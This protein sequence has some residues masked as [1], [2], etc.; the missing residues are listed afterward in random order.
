[1]AAHNIA[2][3]QLSELKKAHKEIEGSIQQWLQS[4]HPQKERLENG[5]ATI[6][7]MVIGDNP[8]HLHEK[9]LQTYISG[10]YPGEEYLPFFDNCCI[11]HE[12]DGHHI[13]LDLWSIEGKG[14]GDRYR[15]LVYSQTNVFILLYRDSEAD[16][17]ENIR[18]CW[19][20]EAG[21]RCGVPVILVAE[22]EPGAVSREE[23]RK[24]A[25]EIG[26]IAYT[27]FS[28]NDE[29]VHKTIKSIFA[30]AM[31]S[32]LLTS[33]QADKYRKLLTS[34]MSPVEALVAQGLIV[35]RPLVLQQG[36]AKQPSQN[37][38]MQLH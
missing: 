31:V 19:G 36:D 1:M 29:A 3:L 4:K 6:K 24:L 30:K 33:E 27:E 8:D 34:V 10:V 25:A 28:F 12:F 11:P 5:S 21:E 32:A 23:G 2:E 22:K 20:I 26:A 15:A 35:R 7:L 14:T 17:Y 18:E 16:C 13:D 9:L 37:S 38:S